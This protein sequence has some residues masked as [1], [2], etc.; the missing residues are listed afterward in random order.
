[1]I[2]EQRKIDLR[3]VGYYVVAPFAA[4][5]IRSMGYARWLD[6][7]KALSTRRP[8]VVVGTTRTKLPDMDMSAGT[9]LQQLNQAT[10]SHGGILSVLDGTPLRVLMALLAKAKALVGLD[11]GPL[12]LAQGLRTPA[13]SLWGPVAP[14]ARIG[15]DRDYMDLCLWDAAACPAAPCFAF[16]EFPESKCPQGKA[17]REC[18]VLGAV[19]VDNVL[20]KIDQIET[21]TSA[22]AP[23]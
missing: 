18:E 10:G 16:I 19:T 11:S 1:M 6:I 17:Q 2:W 22:Y 7:I 20:K 4:A 14:A 3:R 21:T 9:F 13:V 5:T 12:Y 8:V 15:Y 23:A